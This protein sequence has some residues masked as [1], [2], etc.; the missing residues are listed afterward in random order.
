MRLID[1]A[2]AG[3]NGFSFEHLPE[4]TPTECQR[5]SQWEIQERV[6]TQH[7]TC[8]LLSY[9]VLSLTATLGVYTILLPQVVYNPFVL[10]RHLAQAG[11]VAHHTTARDRSRQFGEFPHYLLEC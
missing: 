2:I 6:L 10:H 4:Y 8:L 5:N 1:V 9:N 3:Q 11:G 7:P